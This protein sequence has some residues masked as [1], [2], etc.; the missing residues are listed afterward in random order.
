MASRI[1]IAPEGNPQSFFELRSR[2][3]A[4]LEQSGKSI[5]GG[6]VVFADRFGAS[7][8]RFV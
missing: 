8:G 4:Q 6:A 7:P 1:S 3:G 5:V 2:A